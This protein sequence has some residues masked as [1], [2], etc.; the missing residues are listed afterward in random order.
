MTQE[1]STSSSTAVS[2]DEESQADRL[3]RLLLL[4]SET[5][6]ID[7]DLTAPVR[8]NQCIKR[9]E[10]VLQRS[11]R[12]TAKLVGCDRPWST[13]FRD[14]SSAAKNKA[15]EVAWSQLVRAGCEPP[16]DLEGP[17][18]TPVSNDSS[19][20]STNASLQE[21]PAKRHQP[22][23]KASTSS[24]M[25]SKT[26]VPAETNPKNATQTI[27]SSK[28]NPKKA[29][30]TI[31]S[32]SSK[33]AAVSVSIG[34]ENQ[35]GSLSSKKAASSQA[36]VVIAAVPV[37]KSTL[38]PKPPPK[39]SSKPEPK[40]R[41]LVSQLKHT[42][43]QLEMTT[44]MMKSQIDTQAYQISCLY[45]QIQAQ[46]SQIAYFHQNHPSSSHSNYYQPTYSRS[47]AP[48]ATAT[49]G[50]NHNNT[51]TEASGAAVLHPTNGTPSSY[52]NYSSIVPNATAAGNHNGK[53]SGGVL[54]PPNRNPKSYPNYGNVVPNATGHNGDVVGGTLVHHHENRTSSYPN[55]GTVVPNSGN[56]TEFL[57]VAQIES[58]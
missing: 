27:S 4:G 58:V 2:A 29:S 40:P 52:P 35:N 31:S 8:C 17:V 38:E 49:A 22:E 18:R 54:P 30:Q 33:V 43:A 3:H 53:V 6:C 28:V 57:G 26:F 19:S 21:P 16:P 20:S 39:A 25:V 36:A 50:N 46:G 15:Y 14:S 23:T 55:C 7:L 9:A 13:T 32:S 5:T 10:S 24:P 11:K 45:Q 1:S 41:L 51:T 12:K 47:D 34:K 56:S 48:H 44:K 42:V 37:T